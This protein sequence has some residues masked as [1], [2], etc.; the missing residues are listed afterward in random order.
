MVSLIDINVSIT[1]HFL[2][3]E[4]YVNLREQAVR[5]KQVPKVYSTGISCVDK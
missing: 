4:K 2:A 1:S 3:F 5:L